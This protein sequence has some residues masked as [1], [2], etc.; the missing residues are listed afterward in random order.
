MVDKKANDYFFL[1]L[2]LLV[3]TS[4]L[5]MLAAAEAQFA[6]DMKQQQD[7]DNCWPGGHDYV[8]VRMRMFLLTPTALGLQFGQ[9][10]CARQ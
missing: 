5:V 2:V 4:F 9:D 1:I 10:T 7:N 8:L 3:V 6:Y